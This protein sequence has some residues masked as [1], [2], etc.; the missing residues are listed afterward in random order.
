MDAAL[1][2][3]GWNK[4]PSK[5][6]ADAIAVTTAGFKPDARKT[7]VDHAVATILED[8]F[9][10]GGPKPI[11]DD[12]DG[13][14]IILGLV[15]ANVF[16]TKQAPELAKQALLDAGVALE[17]R[18]SL[19]RG[20]SPPP[21]P[22]PAVDDKALMGQLARLGLLPPAAGKRTRRPPSDDP[23]PQS[24]GKRKPP[25]PPDDD[26]DDDNDD[27]DDDDDDDE[28][29]DDDNADGN[30]DDNDH[31][32][33]STDTGHTKTTEKGNNSRAEFSKPKNFLEPGRWRKFLLGK[34]VSTDAVVDEISRFYRAAVSKF[35]PETAF[36]LDVLRLQSSLLAFPGSLPDA[37]VAAAVSTVDRCLARFEFF[38]AKTRF[39]TGRAAQATEARLLDNELPKR[40]RE[41]RR[42]GEKAQAGTDRPAPAQHTASAAVPPKKPIKKPKKNQN[43]K[44]KN[45]NKKDGKADEPESE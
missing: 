23:P 26:D 19:S 35:G 8:A 34:T 32:D 39:P 30:G 24:K 7:V 41:G 33:G 12:V 6:L 28:D 3:M 38:A 37:V 4:K 9:Q 18:R 15:A 43:K 44:D 27:D 36:L 20:F 17:A 21:V 16:P 29:D 45:K 25:P 11:A 13:A 5:K 42:Q 10:E 40:F 22:P 14:V 2:Q 1:L 31:D